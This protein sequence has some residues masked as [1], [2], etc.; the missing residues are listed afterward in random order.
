MN[1]NNSIYYLG[2]SMYKKERRQITVNK[3]LIQ[4]LFEPCHDSPSHF[5]GDAS[6]D[7][8][9]GEGN[10]GSGAVCSGG[11]CDVV[12]SVSVSLQCHWWLHLQW[13]YC[14]WQHWHWQ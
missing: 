6:S 11:V 14:H 7:S 1:I 13:W 12:S 3:F 4:H 8:I 10:V 9:D 5:A 2:D